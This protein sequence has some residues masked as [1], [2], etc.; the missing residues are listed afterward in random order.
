MLWLWV[1]ITVV[2][3]FAVVAGTMLERRRRSAGTDPHGGDHRSTRIPDQHDGGIP[4]GGF[5]GMVP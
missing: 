3:V 2:A 1:T 5:G 4:G